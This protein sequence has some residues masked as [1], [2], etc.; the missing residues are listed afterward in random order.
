MKFF[1][2][3]FIW[4]CLLTGTVFAQEGG[5][6]V[7]PDT[8]EQID[9]YVPTAPKARMFAGRPGKAALYSLILPGAGQVYNQKYWKVPLVWGAVGGTGW[10]MVDNAK[11]YRLFRDIYR[12]RLIADMEDMPHT[13]D[14]TFLSNEQIRNERERWNRFRQM[15]IFIFALSW[16][17]NSAE[18]FVDAHL[19]DFDTSDDLSIEFRPAD[20]DPAIAAVQTGIII[21]F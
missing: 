2:A 4:I 13:D 12:D 6:S 7:E 1:S 11:K 18:A 10:V 21:R 9:G 19:L 15:S 3:L 16:I 20:Y 17:A 5:F 8:V 14:Y